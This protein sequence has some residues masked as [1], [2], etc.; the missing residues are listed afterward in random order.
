MGPWGLHYERTQTW[1]EMAGP[2]HEYL[3]RCQF[4]LRQGLFVADLCYL[5]PELPNQTYFTPDPQIPDGYKYDQCSAEALMARMTVKHGRLQL[6]D[7]MSYR[8][9]VLPANDTLMTPALVRK[10]KQLVAAGATVIGPRPTASPSLQDFPKCDEEVARLAE[11]IWGPCDGKTVTEHAYGKGRVIWG[12]PLATVLEQLPSAPDF[13]ST[14]K[15]NWIHRTIGDTEVYFVANPAGFAAETKCTFRVKGRQPELWDPQT[16]DISALPIYENAAA[17]VA[18][19]L[20]FEPSGS[21]FVVFR[22]QK[23]QSDP[24]VRFTRDTKAV[25]PVPK[26][27]SIRIQRATYGV[28]GDAQRTRNVQAKVQQFIDLGETTFQVGQ[29]AEGDDPAYGIVKTLV[30]DFTIGDQSISVTGQDPDTV[31]FV[32]TISAPDRAAEIQRDPAGKLRVV[33]SEPGHYEVKTA[34]GLTLRADVAAVPPPIDLGGRWD[35]R[36][37]PHWGAPEQI[38][39]DPL[40]SLSLSTN[41]GVKYFSGTATYQKTFDWHPAAQ[42]NRQSEIWLDLGDV[43]VM[44]RVKLNGHDLGIL[45][46]APFRVDIASALR[47]GQNELEIRVADLWPNRMIGDAALP[48][49]ERFTWSSYEPFT[50]DTPLPPSGLLGPVVIHSTET[51]PLQ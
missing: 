34:K 24:V 33:A 8:L 35:V 49:K 46:K 41:A 39:L 31:A 45:W 26:P 38:T 25:A 48:E 16:G 10:I 43:Q 13:A 2:W 4:M 14:A 7:G 20:R 1:W 36:F 5:R 42:E 6:P 18:V 51:V 32:Q 40:R 3:S 15:L 12:Q 28:P 9:L 50:R 17:G 30:V 22:P 21:E 44:A 27:P 47:P 23:K 19:P 11:E 29:L 37:P